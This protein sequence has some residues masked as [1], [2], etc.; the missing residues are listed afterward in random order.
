MV[1]SANLSQSFTKAHKFCVNFPGTFKR[2]LLM[3]INS[4]SA[5][6]SCQHF[7]DVRSP[8]PLMR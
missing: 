3:R 6:G 5:L 4:P 8:F 7:P 1:P 2:H